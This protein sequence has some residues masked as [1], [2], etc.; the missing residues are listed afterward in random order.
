MLYHKTRD[1]LQVMIQLGYRN[2]QHTLVHTHL[3]N[4][5]DDDYVSAVAKTVSVAQKLIESGFEYTCTMEN[6]TIFRKRK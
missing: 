2:L 5:A 3:V 1:I 4:F 6:F